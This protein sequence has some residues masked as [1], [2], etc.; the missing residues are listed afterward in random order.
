LI[1]ELNGQTGGKVLAGMSGDKLNLFHKVYG[2]EAL[3][4]Q[5]RR[6]VAAETI[7]AGWRRTVDGFRGRRQRYLLYT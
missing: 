1:E 2:S 6:G 5:L 3:H 4:A 7:V